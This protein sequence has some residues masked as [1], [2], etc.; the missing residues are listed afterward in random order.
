MD[1]GPSHRRWG[2]SFEVPMMD[3]YSGPRDGMAH[4]R[5]LSLLMFF[6]EILQ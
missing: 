3:M 2:Y 5:R 4:E 1:I 6:K